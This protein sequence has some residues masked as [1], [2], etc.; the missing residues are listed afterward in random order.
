MSIARP[1]MIERQ[2]ARVKSLAVEIGDGLLDH[3][4]VGWL[5]ALRRHFADAPVDGVAHNRMPDVRAVYAYLM[6]PPS[7]QPGLRQGEQT[8]RFE[9]GQLRDRCARSMA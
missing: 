5:D 9:D 8:Q 4:P 6:R 3:F 7:A 2:A 1:G